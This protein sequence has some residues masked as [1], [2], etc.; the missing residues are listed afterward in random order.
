MALLYMLSLFVLWIQGPN[1]NKYYIQNSEHD[2]L[3]AKSV[4]MLD[5]Y[6]TVWDCLK[7]HMIQQ[8]VNSFEDYFNC[9]WD[10]KHSDEVQV[11]QYVRQYFNLDSDLQAH[12]NY[13][14]NLNLIAIS[15]GAYEVFVGG[16]FW[17][18]W[19]MPFS[20][21]ALHASHSNSICL[22]QRPISSWHYFHQQ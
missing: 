3:I 7:Y 16:P 5:A 8:M 4:A 1:L 12:V 2:D 20:L 15:W 22:N 14:V 21:L 17:N 9:I 10:W 6:P 18:D 11:H 13:T 19:A